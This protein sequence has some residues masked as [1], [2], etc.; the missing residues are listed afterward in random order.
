MAQTK[1]QRAVPSARGDAQWQTA[2]R[3]EDTIRQ[4]WRREYGDD[5]V[6][7]TRRFYKP[8]GSSNQ[9]ESICKPA[10]LLDR[11]SPSPEFK[12]TNQRLTQDMIRAGMTTANKQMPQ[13]ILQRSLR[14]TWAARRTPSPRQ[15]VV[16]R[17]SRTTCAR[18]ELDE[19]DLAKEQLP[20]YG[21]VD[22]LG[23]VKRR[24]V[25]TNPPYATARE[26]VGAPTPM[27]HVELEKLRT[28]KY[29]QNTTS[30]VNALLGAHGKTN[31]Q[32]TRLMEQSMRQNRAHTDVKMDLEGAL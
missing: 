31:Y 30:T 1:G 23:R 19:R 7:T 28:Q 5:F 9:N 15:P 11:I 8:N 22:S 17:L 13:T 27:L 18:P 12:T 2:L 29:I 6:A 21:A 10:A 26:F 25:Y 32:F 14:K 20:T 24:A 16:T 3:K 4:A